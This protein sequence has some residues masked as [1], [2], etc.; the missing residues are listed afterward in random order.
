MT[1][2]WY[3]SQMRN[4][5]TSTVD[6]DVAALRTAEELMIALVNQKGLVTYY[7]LSDDPDWL[8]QLETQQATFSNWLRKAQEKTTEKVSGDILARIASE[9]AEYVVLRN[10]VIELY[11]A[12]N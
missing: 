10:Q 12:G 5:F 11:R 9:Y 7:F 2:F 3:A 1:T 4:L 6:R 8:K